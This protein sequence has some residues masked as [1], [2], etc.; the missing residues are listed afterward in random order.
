MGTIIIG[1]AVSAGNMSAFIKHIYL[2]LQQLFH[3]Q[4]CSD[5]L[6]AVLPLLLTSQAL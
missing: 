1:G 6:T 3:E 5:M 4:W 2:V